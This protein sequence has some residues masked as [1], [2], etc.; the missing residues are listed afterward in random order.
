MHTLTTAMTRITKDNKQIQKVFHCKFTLVLSQW[1]W[2]FWQQNQWFDCH[3]SLLKTFTFRSAFFI[4]QIAKHL[5]VNHKTNNFHQFIINSIVTV[6][7]IVTCLFQWLNFDDKWFSL[8]QNQIWLIT[9]LINDMIKLND[10]LTIACFIP[11]YFWFRISFT[12]TFKFNC[13]TN[14]CSFLTQINS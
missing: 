11:C 1:R 8:W 13:F 4:I 6:T 12:K 9:L 2:Y 3:I 7:F 5:T 14:F 10:Q